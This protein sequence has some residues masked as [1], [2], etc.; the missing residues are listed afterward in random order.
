M[1]SRP[2]WQ[3]AAIATCF[4]VMGCS[5]NPPAV[6]ERTA[7]ATPAEAPVVAVVPAGEHSDPSLVD[8]TVTANLD[9]NAPWTS[10]QGEAPQTNSAASGEGHQSAAAAQEEGPSN[11]A[12]DA[13]SRQAN[14]L[15]EAP[16]PVTASPQAAH[17]T[18]TVDLA[19]SGEASRTST[20]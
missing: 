1:K 15:S 16:A 9:P 13:G 19:K 7:D 17:E 11:A 3:A 10:P 18:P 14:A 2:C 4:A 8:S 6:P 12:Q 20:N 5:R